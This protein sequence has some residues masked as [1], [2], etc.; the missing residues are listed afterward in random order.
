MTFVTSL[1]NLKMGS[2][3]MCPFSGVAVGFKKVPLG[4]VWTSRLL[5]L[6]LWSQISPQGLG[7]G[8]QDARSEGCALV[9][10][11]SSFGIIGS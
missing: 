3:R 10:W 7:S 2:G 4:K 8:A 9:P 6:E 5:T 11:K 1:G